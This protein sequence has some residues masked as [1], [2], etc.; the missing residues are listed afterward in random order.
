MKLFTVAGCV[1][2]S[3]SRNMNVLF[4]WGTG[5]VLCNRTDAA[6]LLFSAVQSR[7]LSASEPSN[8][9]FLLLSPSFLFTSSFI[10]INHLN[11]IRCVIV[12]CLPVPFS[13]TRSVLLSFLLLMW[14]HWCVFLKQY[15]VLW[16][17]PFCFKCKLLQSWAS[18][19]LD[20]AAW[21]VHCKLNHW[22]RAHSSAGQHKNSACMV[23]CCS[24]IHLLLCS[25]GY[26]FTFPLTRPLASF[27]NRLVA[28]LAHL[29]SHSLSNSFARLNT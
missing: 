26:L 1:P 5:T 7:R 29:L 18:L 20:D 4:S 21:W 6:V 8:S 11:Q 19:H 13:P 23:C 15:F 28:S 24:M 17:N 16:S 25:L 22:Q 2:F 14:W 3:G 12:L 9:L 27:P 10:L